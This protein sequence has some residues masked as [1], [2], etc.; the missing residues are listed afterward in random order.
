MSMATSALTHMTR[1]QEARS[2]QRQPS[3]RNRMAGLA[4]LDQT[5]L[6]M[7]MPADGF[8]MNAALKY[9]PY[10]YF[11]LA[12]G[13]LDELRVCAEEYR[14]R[15]LV[16]PL[17][18]TV[19]ILA[20]DNFDSTQRVNNG[21]VL[22]GF[23]FVAVDG[24]VADFE[25]NISIICDQQ[26]YFDQT[27]DATT[28]RPTPAAALGTDLFPVLFEPVCLWGNP[29]PQLKVVIANK[30]DVDQRCQLLIHLAEPCQ[31]QGSGSGPL[32]AYPWSPGAQGT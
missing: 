2:H 17:D 9:L 31:A 3:P 7:E 23:N 28:L 15:W 29:Y 8:S 32:P 11:P 14:A 26:Q 27:V 21:S 10:R 5:F 25:V 19:P 18:V 1:A 13:Q 4:D 24:E 16:L 6:P 30:A 12:L 20:F 22:Y